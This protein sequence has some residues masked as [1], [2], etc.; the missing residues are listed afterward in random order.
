MSASLIRS[1]FLIKLNPIH[2]FSEKKIYSR[3]S[4]V[5]NLYINKEIVVHRGNKL[6]SKYLSLWGVGFKFG[7]FT[8]N[9]KLAMYKRKQKKS[10]KKFYSW[11]IMQVG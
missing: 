1:I 8:W 7:E 4:T 6:K 9:R 11:Y 2:H 10:K 5:P 3:N